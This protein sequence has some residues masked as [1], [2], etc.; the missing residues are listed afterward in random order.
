MLNSVPGSAASLSPGS[1]SG[2]SNTSLPSIHSTP[3]LSSDNGENLIEVEYLS[4]FENL[5]SQE[6]SATSDKKRKRADESWVPNKSPY[7]PL[8]ITYLM[9]K[10]I[11]GTISL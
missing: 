2:N 8:Y 6:P 5:D 3:T 11:V 7:L 1:V 4:R 10:L 9:I